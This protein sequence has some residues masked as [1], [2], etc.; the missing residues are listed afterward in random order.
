MEINADIIRKMANLGDLELTEERAS[1]SLPALRQ[2]LE[3]SA[4]LDEIDLDKFTSVGDLWPEVDR[5]NG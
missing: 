2:I 1:L 3:A 4:Q 5:E